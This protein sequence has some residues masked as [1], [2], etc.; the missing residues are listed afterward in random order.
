MSLD[1]VDRYLREN[2]LCKWLAKK[3]PKLDAAR[4]KERLAWALARKDWTAEDFESTS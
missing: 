1:T 3:R 2:G 4:A